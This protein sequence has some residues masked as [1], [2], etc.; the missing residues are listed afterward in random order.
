MAHPLTVAFGEYLWARE[1]P[2]ATRRQ[3]DDKGNG[4]QDSR[5][6]AGYENWR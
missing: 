4:I 5:T 1:A 3:R 2:A 6:P